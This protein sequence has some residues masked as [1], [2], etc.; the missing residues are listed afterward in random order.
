MLA[1]L[2]GESHGS[3]EAVLR[4]HPGRVEIVFAVLGVIPATY[5]TVMLTGMLNY[6]RYAFLV[7]T[8]LGG[9]I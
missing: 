6:S 9:D 4:K 7:E 5:E 2:T 8:V 1:V 3:C